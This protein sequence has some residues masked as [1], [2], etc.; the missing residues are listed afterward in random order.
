VPSLRELLAG[1]EFTSDW[2]GPSAEGDRLFLAK[3]E[4][5]ENERSIYYIRRCNC[6]LIYSTHSL[7]IVPVTWFTR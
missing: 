4:M 5:K 7:Q 2:V 3:P 6:L 1:T